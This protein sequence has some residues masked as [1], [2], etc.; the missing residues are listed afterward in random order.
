[1]L[2]TVEKRFVRYWE[3]QREGGFWAYCL[4]Y[5]LAGTFVATLVL[6]FVLNMFSVKLLGLIWKIP[7]VSFVTIAI[8]IVLSWRRNEQ[9]LRN[10]IQREVRE[11]KKLDEIRLTGKDLDLP[12]NN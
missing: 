1:M 4:L 6:Y 10:L 11:A 8:S 12:R 5:L 7:S 2:N 9:K 3:E